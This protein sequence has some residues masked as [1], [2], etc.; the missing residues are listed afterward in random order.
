MKKSEG[1]LTGFL[2]SGCVLKGD[3]TFSDQLRIHGQV[4][5]TVTSDH[6]LLIGEGGLVEG[7]V[8][9]GRLIV[10]GTVRGTVKVRECMVVHRCGKVFAEIHTPSLVVEEGGV[11]DGLVHMGGA[12]HAVVAPL[13]TMG[14][15][16]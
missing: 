12:E 14:R 3:L 5:G 9:V 13:D 4:E 1:T 2:D 6:E 7:S 16:G 11:V 15:R 10:S 8:N